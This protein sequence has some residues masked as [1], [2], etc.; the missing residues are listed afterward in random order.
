MSWLAK[1]ATPPEEKVD[2]VNQTGAK[3]LTEAVETLHE[4]RDLLKDA[5]PAPSPVN[6]LP[7]YGGQK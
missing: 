6:T 7:R 4:I 5:Q 1:P 3:L 2:D